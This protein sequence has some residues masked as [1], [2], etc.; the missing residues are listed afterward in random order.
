MLERKATQMKS[1]GEM[2]KKNATRWAHVSDREVVVFNLVLFV[3]FSN[4]L[5]EQKFIN[6]S[7]DNFASGQTFD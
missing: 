7:F 6:K 5:P 3:C 2:Q 4:T 1:A